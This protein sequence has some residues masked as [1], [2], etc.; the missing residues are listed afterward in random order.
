[1]KNNLIELMTDCCVCG[2]KTTKKHI[3]GED[4]L[5]KDCKDLTINDIY[6]ILQ[7]VVRDMFMNDPIFDLDE[8]EMFKMFDSILENKELK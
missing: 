8:E 3:F 6:T 1:M 4:F 2:C 7:D 5:C